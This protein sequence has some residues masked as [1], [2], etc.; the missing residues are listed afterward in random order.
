[1]SRLIL[2]IALLVQAACMPSFDLP[3]ATVPAELAANDSGVAR[4]VVNVDHARRHVVVYAGPYH[5]PCMDEAD[6]DLPHDLVG[7]TEPVVEFAWPVRGWLRGFAITLH[8]EDGSEI[9]RDLMH[10]LIGYNLDRRP[11]I[12]PGIERLFGAGLET[13]DVVLPEAFGVPVD[14]GN[15][16]A[17]HPTWHNETGEDIHGVF[18][19]VVLPYTPWRPEGIRIEGLPFHAEVNFSLDATTAFD[20]PPGRSEHSFEFV[21]PLDGGII[22]ASG[23]MHDYGLEMRL[24][25]LDEGRV[26]L[27]L[28]GKRDR[29]GKLLA[30]E[31]KVYR[32]WFGL[33]DA[34]VRLHEGRRYRVVGEY[35]NPTGRTLP[36][37]AMA[38]IVGMFAPDDL[39]RWP[40][41]DRESDE[42]KH[43]IAMIRGEIPRGA[44]AGGHHHH[45]E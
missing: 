31:R 35:D 14:E 32:S 9:S 39:S 10:H 45:H 20:L 4:A 42:V 37:G 30:M 18:I 2:P 38:H 40:V 26:V 1:M 44:A 34:R 36:F 5:I 19:R 28:R 29:E 25:D 22:G 33:K 43:D 23:H 6:H 21:M 7:H 17:F 15:T 11:L 8:R 16:L 27:R 24:E 12:H 41:L 13:K 3:P